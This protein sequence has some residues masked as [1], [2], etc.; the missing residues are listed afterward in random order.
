PRSFVGML[1]DRVAT[2]S[3]CRTRGGEVDRAIA[4]SAGHVELRAELEEAHRVGSRGGHG[5][6]SIRSTGGRLSRSRARPDGALHLRLHPKLETLAPCPD[7]DR[8][9]TW[10]VGGRDVRLLDGDVRR[11]P[12]RPLGA[13]DAEGA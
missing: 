3:L 12:Q 7:A 8:A 4:N 11:E 9:R 10:S 1:C 2:K 6:S 13:K 5:S